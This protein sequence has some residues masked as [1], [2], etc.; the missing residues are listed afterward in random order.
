MRG[1]IWY[2][3]EEKGKEFLNIIK[4]QYN[5]MGY[6]HYVMAYG[7]HG[8]LPT[9]FFKKENWHDEDSWTLLSDKYD[10]NQESPWEKWN[11]AY[12]DFEINNEFQNNV[13]FP[14]LIRGP[15]QGWQI[16]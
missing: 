16:Y 14:S 6:E 2:H 8:G 9:I 1:I 3:T 13:I 4:E 12:I 11:Y 10:W 15:F 7:G 5:K